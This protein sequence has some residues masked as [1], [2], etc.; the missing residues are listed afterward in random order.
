[1][2]P[3]S[4]QPQPSHSVLP[5]SSTP[6]PPSVL[7]QPVLSPHPPMERTGALYT[8]AHK[9]LCALAFA[10]QEVNEKGNDHVPTEKQQ[11]QEEATQRGQHL[12][13]NGEPPNSLSNGAAAHIARKRPARS[14]RATIIIVS[15][16]K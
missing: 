9:A 13:N 7:T 12:C 5:P 2:P 10:L 8:A 15:V 16:P 1:M 4:E 3:T 14:L 11:A 6:T